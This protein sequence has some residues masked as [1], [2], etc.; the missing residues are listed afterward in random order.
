MNETSTST[1]KA[2]GLGIQTAVKKWVDCT[3]SEK[4]EKL[5]EELLNHR[6]FSRSISELAQK[7]RRLFKH[8]HNEKTGELQEKMEEYNYSGSDT[9]GL[10]RDILA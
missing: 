2:Q 3:D 10:S 6:Y 9:V 7:V 4:I 8:S 5:R 1:P